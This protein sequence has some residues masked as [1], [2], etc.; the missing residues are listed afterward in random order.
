M[1]W[2]RLFC[3]TYF[4]AKSGQIYYVNSLLLE[5]WAAEIITG[6]RYGAGGTLK[7]ILLDG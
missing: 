6:S 1:H 2:D 4:Y 3:N 7:E 5:Y